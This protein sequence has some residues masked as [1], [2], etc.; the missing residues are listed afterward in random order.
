MNKYLTIKKSFFSISSFGVIS[1]INDIL[2]KKSNYCTQKI[3]TQKINTQKINTQKINTKKINTQK[4]NTQ[5]INTQKINTQKISPCEIIN[6]L[7]ISNS[8]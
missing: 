3:H 4:I 7:M 8:P 5:K 1:E 2:H 6:N